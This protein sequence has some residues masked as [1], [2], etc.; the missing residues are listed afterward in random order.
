M[1]VARGL[2]RAWLTKYFSTVS[3][4]GLASDD[5]PIL[6]RRIYVPLILTKEKVS[7]YVPEDQIHHE[8]QP[9]VSWLDSPERGKVF[10]IS[11]EAG[12]GKTTLV[13]AV[14]DSFSG[15]VGDDLNQRFEGYVPFPIRLREAPI[16]R[17]R[18]LDWLVDWW[19]EQAHREVPELDPE[20]VRSF[21][22]MGRGIILLDGLD[23]VGSL[24]RRT[25]VM[26]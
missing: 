8:G 14:V 13:S 18:S 19:L 1:L 20:S 10:L 6:L 2:Y 25:R 24:E 16:E 7:D 3:L 11:G 17:L 5:E 21:L 23:E 22:D 4:A 15:E 26:G 12:S 9:L